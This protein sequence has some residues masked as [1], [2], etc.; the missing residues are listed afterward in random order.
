MNRCDVCNVRIAPGA[1]R[2]PLCH[3]ELTDAAGSSAE[4]V[5]P[6]FYTMRKKPSWIPGFVSGLAVAAIL[7]CVLINILTWNGIVWSAIAGFGILYLWLGGLITFQKSIHLAIK[8]MTHAVFLSAYLLIIN[9]FAS[10]HITVSD[11]TWA[12]SYGM[13]AVLIAFILTITVMLRGTRHNRGEYLL[14]QLSLCIIGFIPLIW[15]F[16]DITEP[17]YPSFFAAGF[18]YFTIVELMVVENRNI[19]SELKKRFHL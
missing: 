11:I 2:C 18:S 6:A 16:I 1:H 8:L 19:K 17:L 3:K 10:D 4:T 14:A 13:P 15:V 5:F 7:V 12:V 9:L